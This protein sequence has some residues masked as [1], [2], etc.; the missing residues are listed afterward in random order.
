MR[1]RNLVP[2]LTVTVLAVGLS[3]WVAPVTADVT[4][5]KTLISGQGAIGA[6]DGANHFSLDGGATFAPAFIIAK[7]PA[8][9]GPI[10]GT[11]WINFDPTFASLPG[12]F[13]QTTIYQTHFN[14]PATFA[15]P[16]LTVTLL[17]DNGASVFLN[18]NLVGG[19]GFAGCPGACPPANFTVPTAFAD[20]NAAHFQKGLNVL[21][22]HVTDFG[23][24]AGLDYRA[25]IMY[26]V[27]GKGSN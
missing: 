8:W 27:D 17:A 10:A 12:P 24:A 19:Q 26:T 5:M 1:N 20:A 21:E 22:F 18:G 16:S 6:H 25:T 14:L 15:A 2:F 9:G 7:H 13:P 11:K 4:K 23:V 3:W